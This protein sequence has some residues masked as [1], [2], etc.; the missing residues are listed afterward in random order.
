VTYFGW[1]ATKPEP[2]AQWD[3]RYRGW[4]LCHGR[5]GCRSDCRHVLLVDARALSLAD[6]EEL[7]EADRPDWRLLMIGIEDPAERAFLLSS[8]CAEALPSSI[9]SS[10]LAARAKRVTDMFGLIPR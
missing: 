2:P 7:V 3:L 9:K 4:E 8:G 6:R 1:L 10:E 5:Q